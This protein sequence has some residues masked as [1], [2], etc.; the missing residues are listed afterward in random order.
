VIEWFHDAVIE[1]PD[2]QAEA[3]RLWAKNAEQAAGASDWRSEENSR[4]QNGILL[5]R[6][7]NIPHLPPEP[8]QW[9]PCHGKQFVL[10]F[11]P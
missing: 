11:S 9:H 4:L 3:C 1:A 10:L 7:T 5:R 2:D 8:N 6:V